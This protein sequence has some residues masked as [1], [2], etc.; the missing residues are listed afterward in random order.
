M[1]RSEKGILFSTPMV[2][3]ILEGRKT[4]T[5]RLD[6]L[7]E[8]NKNPDEWILQSFEMNPELTHWDKDGNMYPKVKEGLIAT[9]E[10]VEYGEVYRNIRCRYEPGTVL[11]VRETWNVDKCDSNCP[12][13]IDEDECPFNRVNDLCYRYKTQYTDAEKMKWKQSIFMP[14]EAARLFLEVQNVRVERVRD[15]SH[16]DCLKEGISWTEEGPLH[17]H[18]IDTKLN[19]IL[20]F[21]TAKEAFKSLWDSINAKRG[22]GW[23]TNPFVWVV[24]FK[25]QEGEP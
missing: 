5:R 2:Q 4:Q 17:A 24:E 16:N 20:N 25:R 21:K 10:N 15:I 9:F 3:A 14:R 8:V 19:A 23:D 22:H 7:H 12:G 11:W 13:R 18:Y 6:G 1:N